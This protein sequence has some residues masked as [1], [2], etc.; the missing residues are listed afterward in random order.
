M[1]GKN[2]KKKQEI[3]TIDLEDAMDD[4]AEEYPVEGE[5][6]Y[7][8][9]QGPLGELGEVDLPEMPVAPRRTRKVVKRAQ[10]KKVESPAQ[11]QEDSKASEYLDV[12]EGHAKRLY[13]SNRRC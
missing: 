3:P 2:K 13:L 6:E 10:P 12:I 1:F 4:G 9:E 11:E 7:D 5:E 8:D